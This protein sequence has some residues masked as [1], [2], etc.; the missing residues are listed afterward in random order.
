LKLLGEKVVYGV[1]Q[2][3]IPEMTEINNI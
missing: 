2:A 1:V 3:K